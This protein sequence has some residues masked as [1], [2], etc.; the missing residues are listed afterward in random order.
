MKWIVLALLAVGGTP[1]Y[2]DPTPSLVGRWRVVGC[3]TSPRDPANCARG[4]I[5]FA[6][7]RWSISLPCCKRVHAYS[8]VSATATKI[9]ISSG[10]T[11]SEIRLDADGT[12]HWAPGSLGGRVGE[13]SFVR[14]K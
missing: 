12:A 1:G 13:L 6:K 7:Q 9:T 4:V 2:A 3:A 14:A 8:V 11:R 5:V 10:G